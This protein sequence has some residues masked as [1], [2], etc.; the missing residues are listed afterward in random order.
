MW[1]AVASTKNTTSPTAAA[2]PKGRQNNPTASPTAA[3]PF[4]TPRNGSIESGTPTA[5]EF[6]LTQS[7]FMKFATDSIALKRTLTKVTVT[8]AM[9]IANSSSIGSG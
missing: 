3:A 9:T 5:C 4:T 6:C 7:A 2:I 8:S 1:R